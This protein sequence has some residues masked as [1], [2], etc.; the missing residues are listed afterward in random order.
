MTA[1]ELT[2]EFNRLTG[3]DKKKFSTK[4]EALNAVT[5][6]QRNIAA[7][8]PN[9][10]SIDTSVVEEPAP[11]RR[12]P[13]NVRARNAE[14]VIRIAVDH[15]PYRDG[16]DAHDHFEKMRGGITVR[17]YLAKFPEKDQRVARQ[18]LWNTK[19]KN[20]VKTIGG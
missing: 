8:S 17:E 2:A 18:W 1:G 16:T 9:V 6:A 11:N 13:K 3:Q 20:F 7:R 12:A 14:E 10:T 4:T 19:N 5:N 15:N